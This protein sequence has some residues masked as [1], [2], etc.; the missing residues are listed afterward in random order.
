MR[1]KGHRDPDKRT[2]EVL[3]WRLSQSLRQIPVW[4]QWALPVFISHLCHSFLPMAPSKKH[5]VTHLRGL[6]PGRCISFCDVSENSTLISASPDPVLCG[7]P[8]GEGLAHRVFRPP[9]LDL[10]QQRGGGARCSPET[11][12]VSLSRGCGLSGGRGRGLE[13]SSDA[14]GPPA[15]AYW[16]GTPGSV[17]K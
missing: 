17:R 15:A 9:G 7:L 10:R 14:F 4:Y 3:L 11:T 13:R 12:D 5:V 6:C 16:S 1:G 8:R 2:L